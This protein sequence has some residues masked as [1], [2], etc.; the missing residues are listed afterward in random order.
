MLGPVVSSPSDNEHESLPP[1]R[2]NKRLGQI[3]TRVDRPPRPSN[4]G[5]PGPRNDRWFDLPRQDPER[6]AWRPGKLGTM[7]PPALSVI[8]A[9]LLLVGCTG[10]PEPTIIERTTGPVT[11]GPMATTSATT[12]PVPTPSVT[13]M[14]GT[15]LPVGPTPGAVLGPLGTVLRFVPSDPSLTFACRAPHVSERHQVAYLGDADGSVVAVD[16]PEGLSVVAYCN[17]YGDPEAMVTDG[18]RFTTIGG[19]WPG[20]HTHA[21][22]ALADGPA[23]HRAAL[24]CLAGQ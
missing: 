14:P 6:P 5:A 10:A 8:A 18:E 3:G 21:G 2:S 23:A 22:V 17:E 9:S 13:Y 16:L 15:Q 24:D 12:T 7:R 1:D 19:G 4:D 11:P 20:S